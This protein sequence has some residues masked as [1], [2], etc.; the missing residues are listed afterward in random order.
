MP[1]RMAAFASCYLLYWYNSS[2]DPLI[3]EHSARARN[4]DSSLPCWHQPTRNEGI[5]PELDAVIRQLHT[6]S[7]GIPSAATNG[8]LK[9]G[10]APRGN[11]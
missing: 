3:N 1:C 2:T 5:I 8:F 11:Q 10:I 7:I 6:K 9:S 4:R